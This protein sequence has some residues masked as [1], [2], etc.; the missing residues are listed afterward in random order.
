MAALTFPQKM[1][2]GA[3]KA[4]GFGIFLDNNSESDF[5]HEYVHQERVRRNC[6]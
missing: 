4:S 1:N 6:A 2:P 3:D 5:S